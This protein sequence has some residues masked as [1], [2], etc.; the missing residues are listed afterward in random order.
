MEGL[1][2]LDIRALFHY[3]EGSISYR[4]GVRP[5]HTRLGGKQ[6]QT[7]FNCPALQCDLLHYISP[8]GSE[9]RS[10]GRSEVRTVMKQL[11]DASNAFRERFS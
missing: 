5:P 1:S 8:R 6:Q 11:S 10:E 4:N 2:D 7:D 9:G 3:D